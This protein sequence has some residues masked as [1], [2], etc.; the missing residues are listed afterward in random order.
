MKGN[1]N[2]D[3]AST[4]NAKQMDLSTTR[5]DDSRPTSKILS[6]SNLEL[7]TSSKKRPHFYTNAAPTKMEGN[8]FRYDFD[9][10]VNTFFI[11]NAQCSNSLLNSYNH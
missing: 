11:E 6:N 3:C 7:A 1:D 8:V 2:S 10:K 4:S 9:D 5:T